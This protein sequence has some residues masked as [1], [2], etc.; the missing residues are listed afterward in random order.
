MNLWFCKILLFKNFHNSL[1]IKIGIV[2]N[3]KEIIN[4]GDNVF[5][6]EFCNRTIHSM[7]N[8]YKS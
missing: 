8:A 6:L 3:L 1:N 5:T 4:N 2:K 7:I